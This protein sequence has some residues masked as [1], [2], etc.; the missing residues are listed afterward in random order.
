MKNNRIQGY[1]DEHMLARW[2]AYK[3]AMN[4]PSDSAALDH[5]VRQELARFENKSSRQ[6][7]LDAMV[8]FQAGI[9]E[10]LTAIAT[11]VSA[12]RRAASINL[13]IQWFKLPT[14]VELTTDQIEELKRTFDRD[15][16]E[17]I[18]QPK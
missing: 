2:E 11:E 6:A 16:V 17:G 8:T 1:I 18:L 4:F 15:L 7:A 10:R 3:T 5:C 14:T 9:D 12:A 13:L